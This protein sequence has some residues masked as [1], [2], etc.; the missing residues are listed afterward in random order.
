M[1]RL[2]SGVA[3]VCGLDRGD[4]LAH[5]VPAAPG[6]LCFHPMRLLLL[7]GLLSSGHRALVS[8]C[9]LSQSV[10]HSGVSG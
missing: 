8:S 4:D 10:E 1:Q 9:G 6:A 7:L 3:S 2:K 5:R